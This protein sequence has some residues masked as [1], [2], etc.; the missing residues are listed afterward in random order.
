[1]RKKGVVSE[2]LEQLEMKQIC[3]QCGSSNVSFNLALE[4]K[5]QVVE[6]VVS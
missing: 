3:P 4:E 2:Q 5:K 6:K 1:M